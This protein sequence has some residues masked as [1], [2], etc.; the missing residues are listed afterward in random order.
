MKKDIIIIGGIIIGAYALI[1][2]LG[3]SRFTWDK[4]SE[5]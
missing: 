2:I 4:I 1:Y 5:E 3:S